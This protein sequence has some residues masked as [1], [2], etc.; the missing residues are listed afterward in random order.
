MHRHKKGA[1]GNRR[2]NASPDLDSRSLPDA[3]EMLADLKR[4][5]EFERH[6]R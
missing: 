3:P 5:R 1:D 4:H 6:W 2:P